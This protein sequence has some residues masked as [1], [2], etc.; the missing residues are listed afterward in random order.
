MKK[1]NHTSQKGITLIALIITIIIMLILVGVTINV[2]LNEGIFQKAEEAKKLTILTADKEELQMEVA[3]AYNVKNSEIDLNLLKTNLEAR[4]WTVNI[5]GD[6]AICT[7]PNKNKFTVDK[8]GELIDDGN[9]SGGENQSDFVN[10]IAFYGPMENGAWIAVDFSKKNVIMIMEENGS[11]VMFKGK[12][13]MLSLEEAI[14]LVDPDEKD[15][16][17]EM[18]IELE[19]NLGKIDS[20]IMGKLPGSSEYTIFYGIILEGKNKVFISKEST[21]VQSDTIL[22]IVENPPENIKNVIYINQANY[23][24]FVVRDI[25]ENINLFLGKAEKVDQI[26]MI[27]KENGIIRMYEYDTESGTS[28]GMVS[29]CS[30][31]KNNEEISVSLYDEP[32]NIININEDFYKI[33]IPD[34][35][36]MYL[37]NMGTNNEKI[38]RGLY[39]Y[40]GLENEDEA[41]VIEL[42]TYDIY[43]LGH[44][45]K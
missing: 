3:S 5:S 12:I 10:E 6:K 4:G 33:E 2:A 34:S 44:C 36:P 15:Y 35:N 8:K 42:G 21:V 13:E 24:S 18:A 9:N 25:T 30:I 26:I 29:K 22:N 41:K 1:Q 28:M 19:E 38:Y 11:S 32:N 43:E 27:D 7:S 45:S 39:Y 23:K 20:V 40:Y 31:I 16:Y 14:N 17:Q 37:E